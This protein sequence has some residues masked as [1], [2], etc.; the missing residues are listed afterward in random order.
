M[1]RVSVAISMMYLSM[2]KRI[3]ISHFNLS[4]MYPMILNCVCPRHEIKKNLLML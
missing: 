3:P 2:P 1:L 4:N